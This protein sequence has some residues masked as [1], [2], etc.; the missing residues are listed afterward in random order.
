MFIEE[1]RTLR[2]RK[3]QDNTVMSR[4]MTTRVEL[5]F[6]SFY[7]APVASVPCTLVSTTRSLRGRRSGREIHEV[8]SCDH[9]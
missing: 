1:G 9:G 7:S 2:G 3:G 6:L 8:E 4:H 5:I